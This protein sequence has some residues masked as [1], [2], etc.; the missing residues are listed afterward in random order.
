MFMFSTVKNS[1]LKSAYK[2]FVYKYL[3]SSK[4]KTKV[5]NI[6]MKPKRLGCEDER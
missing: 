1:D 4:S 2:I 3:K 6:K 5:D